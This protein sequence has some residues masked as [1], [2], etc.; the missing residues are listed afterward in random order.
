MKNILNKIPTLPGHKTYIVALLVVLAG[1]AK[2][3]DVIDEQ[4][5]QIVVAI[6][7]GSGIAS[8]RAAVKKLE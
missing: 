2:V 1:I 4:T 7:A 5:F 8:L 3:Q 6:L